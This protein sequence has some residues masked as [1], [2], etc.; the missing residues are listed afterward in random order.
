MSLITRFL[1]SL[2]VLFAI[3]SCGSEVRTQRHRTSIDF[4]D[5]ITLVAPSKPF[6]GNPAMD[7]DE[8]GA[9]WVAVVP[10]GFTPDDRPIVRYDQKR[11]WW[12]ETREGVIESIRYFHAS[13]LKVML[14]PQ[15]WAHHMWSGDIYYDEKS[16]WLSWEA[17]YTDFI[18]QM[19][20]IADSMQ[21]ELLC[22]G[23]E[24]KKSVAH[25]PEYWSELI[26]QIRQ[27]FQGKLTYAAN[28]DAY[29]VPEFWNQLDYIGINAYFPLV[30]SQDPGRNALNRAWEPIEKDI[31]RFSHKWDKPVLFTEF[32]YL[33]TDYNTH[34][35]WE[36]EDQIHQLAVNEQAQAIALDVLMENFYA[37]D[38][39]AG[40]FLWKWYPP[41]SRIRNKSRDYTIQ[42]K[43]AHDVIQKWY[44][45]NVPGN[46]K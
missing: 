9:D 8:L 1:L 11:Q 10:Y 29:H 35:T 14:K 30:E 31:G 41:G 15:I 25:R 13:G 42:G 33:S 36:R 20:E 6:T 44:T 24:L 3:F 23:T 26:R 43:Q 17:D 18:F 32:G 37:H 7:I 38:W 19:A 27:K 21:V 4:V 5:G 12:G 34:N 40:G 2:F 28:W 45:R 22:I 39:W 46:I 16:E